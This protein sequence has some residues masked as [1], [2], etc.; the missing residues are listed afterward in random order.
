M[1]SDTDKKALA[2]RFCIMG[3][4]WSKTGKIW[5]GAPSVWYS[6]PGKGKTSLWRRLARMLRTKEFPE[7]IPYECLKP[8]ARGEGQ[9]GVTPVPVKL[10]D[11]SIGIDYPA[12][13][14]YKQRFASGLGV[15]NVG[16]SNTA[17]PG[18]A[19]A[20]LALIQEREWGAWFVGEDGDS[21]YNR[22]WLVGDANPTDQAAGAWDIPMNF[23]NRMGHYEYP[24]HTPVE[25]GEYMAAGARNDL[26]DPI[27]CDEEEARMLQVWPDVYSKAVGLVNAYVKAHP[28]AFC[29]DIQPDN[30]RASKA[31]ASERTWEYATRIFATA[32]ARNLSDDLSDDLIGGFVGMENALTF[33]TYRNDLDL[34]DPIQFMNGDVPFEHSLQRLDRTY[35]LLSSCKSR[36][37][38]KEEG[39][40]TDKKL[41]QKWASALWRLLDVVSEDAADL[42][43]PVVKTLWDEGVVGV[44]EAKPVLIKMEPVVRPTV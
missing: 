21:P 15:L 22:I 2:L 34:P 25:W 33:S 31:W 11:G 7:G 18:Y 16:E 29:E 28:D 30:P 35:A 12:P 43:A 41:K 14:Y 19:S 6:S 36:L 32:L 9:F 24:G 17:P 8:G 3:S 20:L 44:E 23:A 40:K 27:D 38:Q 4:N 37:T 26:D 1:L 10:A 5:F 39:K 13:A 42:A